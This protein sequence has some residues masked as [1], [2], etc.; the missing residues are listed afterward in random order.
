MTVGLYVPG[1]SPVHRIPAAWKVIAVFAAGT[2][3][4]AVDDLRVLGVAGGCVVLLYVIAGIGWRVALRQVRPMLPVLLVLCAVQWFT[5]GTASAVLVGMRLVTVILLA[6][7]VTFT[8]RVSEMVGVIE[9]ACSPLERFGV[10]TAKVSLAISMT[11]RFIPLLTQVGHDVREAQRARGLERSMLALAVPM[12]VRALHTAEQV[13]EA[14]D[15]R[16][17]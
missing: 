1:R 3:V 15:A 6:M 17:S 14:I 2:L 5:A 12:L 8:T 13:A 9:R 4:V 10:R 16:G 11:L 7:L